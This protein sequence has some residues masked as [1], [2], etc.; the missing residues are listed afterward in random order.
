MAKAGKSFFQYVKGDYRPTMQ[1]IWDD[2]NKTVTTYLPRIHDEQPSPNSP[3]EH[4]THEA[5]PVFPLVPDPIGHW[6][7]A[8]AFVE[9]EEKPSGHAW[10]VVA[11]LLLW[12][13][14][15]TH[16]RHKVVPLRC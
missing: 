8:N 4:P 5:A 13:F 9:F 15:G 1:A 6:L 14:P 10:Q 12:Y 7:H 11:F 16:G 2:D 3:A